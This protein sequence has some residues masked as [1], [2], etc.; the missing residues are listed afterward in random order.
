VP[1]KIEKNT[2]E[3]GLVE[4]RF[5]L[6]GTE[7]EGGAAEVVDPAGDTLGVVVDESQEGIGEDG[8]L[9]TGDAEMVFDVAS[10]LFEVEGAQ[11]IADGD[12]LMEGLVGSEA[13]LVGQVRLTEEDEG[14][15]GG[16]VHL[17]VEQEAEL[18]E[19]VRGQQVRLVDDEEGVTALAGQVR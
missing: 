10:S 2:F 3:V 17:V 4:D 8:L 13:E 18:V 16:R 1:V 9:T 5:V 19:E 6:G 7:E 11:V 14:E 12:T 15:Q